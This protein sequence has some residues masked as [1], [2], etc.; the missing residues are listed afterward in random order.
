MD[1]PERVLRRLVPCVLLLLGCGRPATQ[2]ECTEIVKR[3]TELELHARGLNSNT[4]DE[5]A[6]TQEALRQS[7]LRECV[8]R[9]LSDEAMSCVRKATSAE[10]IT[11]C[12]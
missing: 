9:R 2:E 6:H 8:G 4:K 3:I 10:Q 5:V 7:T 12:F 11:G 1:N